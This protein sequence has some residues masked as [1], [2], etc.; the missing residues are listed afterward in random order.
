MFSF[1]ITINI[2]I[3]FT[4]PCPRSYTYAK[5]LEVLPHQIRQSLMATILG[6]SK[7]SFLYKRIVA[8]RH[9]RLKKKPC[10]FNNDYMKNS[11]RLFFLMYGFNFSLSN[12]WIGAYL[13]RW[14]CRNPVGL[15]VVDYIILF[16]F[17]QNCS[18]VQKGKVAIS[19]HYNRKKWK[20][21]MCFQYYHYIKKM[22]SCKKWIAKLKFKTWYWF[23]NGQNII[24]L[25]FW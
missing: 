5:F 21:S 15:T 20:P 2:Y 4:H 16:F 24:Q 22:N 7:L 1:W 23:L 17:S 10:A 18:S 8:S 13:C 19:R 25:W 6:C 11:N 3:S 12:T 9:H 14:T